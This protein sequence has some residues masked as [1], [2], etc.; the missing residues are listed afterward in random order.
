M[1]RKRIKTLAHEWNVPVEDV[2]HSCERLKLV[3]GR[4]DSS[5]LTTEE[6]ERVKADLEEQAN[7]AA[8]LRHEVVLETTSGKVVEKRLN[9]G[10]MRG[11]HAEP[12]AI[13]A[14][15]ALPSAG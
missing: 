15:S 3:H 12:A 5:L 9:E 6:A 4:L 2:T 11:R 7:R 8:I 1:A 14:D 13:A 10:I